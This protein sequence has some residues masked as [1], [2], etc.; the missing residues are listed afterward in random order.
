[1]P[2]SLAIVFLLVPT[3]AV[4]VPSHHVS[5]DEALMPAGV[6]QRLG[7]IESWQRTISSPGGAAAI[8]DEQVFVHQKDPQIYVEVVESGAAMMSVDKMGSDKMAADKM[9]AEKREGM[10]AKEM[11]ASGGDAMMK[12]EPAGMQM[13]KATDNAKVLM[14]IA[15]GSSDRLG[16]PIDKKEAERLAGNEIRRMKRRGI[17]A[18][19][20]TTEVRRVVLYSL[21]EDGSLEA[22]DGETGQPLWMVQIGRSD[23]PFREL[24]ISE[25]Y[26]TIVNGANV[27]EVDAATGEVIDEHPTIGVPQFG[28]VNAGGF[29][30]IA[31]LGGGLEGYPLRDPLAD[32]FRKMVAGRALGTPIKSP[33]STK[34][35]WAT[36]QSFVYV[37]ELD[38]QPYELFRLQTDGMV[39]GGIAAADGD[40]FFFAT[41]AGQVYGLRA[42]RSGEVLWTTPFGEP[43]FVKPLALENHLFVVSTYGRMFCLESENG[44]LVWDAPATN[45]GAILGGFGDQIFIRTVGGSFAVVD[46]KTGQTK[47]TVGE[48]RPNRLLPNLKTNRLYL[49]SDAG[50]VQCM[51][52]IDSALPKFSIQPDPQPMAET[53]EKMEKMEKESGPF[54]A[55]GSNPFGAGGGDPFGGGAGGDPFGAGGGDPFGAGAGGDPFGA[56]GGDPFGGGGA[57]EDP[58]GGDPFGN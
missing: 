38:P 7:L 55:G 45:V 56:G 31:T 40:R 34:T 17:D 4:V 11:M 35:A 13:A 6:A 3:I 20:R 36:D 12:S 2:R 16:K 8:V 9:A 22:R 18:T 49:V 48:I 41:D 29:A 19:M 1:M 50:V 33:T 39:V 5:A 15:V 30:V 47:Q 28:A 43:F 26:I 32:P 52:P 10:A 57:I 51:R 23:L 27:L 14:R 24:G 44:N 58:F 53:T 37:M 25:N 46:R 54:D 21:A 42:T